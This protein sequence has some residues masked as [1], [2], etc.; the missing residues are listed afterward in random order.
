M[1]LNRPMRIRWQSL[2]PNGSHRE[3]EKNQGAVPRFAATTIVVRKV[4]YSTTATRYSR[5]IR[6]GQS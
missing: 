6:R 2:S 5:C 3:A 1:K 4:A